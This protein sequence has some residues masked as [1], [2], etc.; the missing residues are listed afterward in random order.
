MVIGGQENKEG[1]SFREGE[2]VYVEG[3]APEICTAGYMVKIASWATVVDTPDPNDKYVLLMIDKIGGDRNAW[4]Y[5]LKDK[6][7]S[8]DSETGKGFGRTR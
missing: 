6:V 7:R 3:D 8:E 2:R 4:V 5:V 1:M